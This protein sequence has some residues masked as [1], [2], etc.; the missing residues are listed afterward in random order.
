MASRRS[1]VSH[2]SCSASWPLSAS[3]CDSW[4]LDRD[5]RQTTL[6]PELRGGDES[7]EQRM[8]A[9]RPA[10]ELRVR[11]GR[12]EERMIVVAQLDEFDEALVGRSARHH[13]AGLLERSAVPVV[14]LVAVTVALV[15]DLLVVEL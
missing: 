11:L 13:H 9:V 8:R 15:D 7:R 1:T 14:H 12:D 3:V 10:L 4:D 6:S 5:V 2:S